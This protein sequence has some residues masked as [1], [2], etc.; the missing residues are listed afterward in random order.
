MPKLISWEAL[1]QQ[2]NDMMDIIREQRAQLDGVFKAIY[3]EPVVRAVL[4]HIEPLRMDLGL[5]NEEI[6]EEVLTILHM[7]SHIAKELVVPQSSKEKE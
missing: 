7:A 2:N 6:E 5:D 1:N 4:S 3:S